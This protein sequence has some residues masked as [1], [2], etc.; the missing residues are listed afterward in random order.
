M[1]PPWLFTCTG[2]VI[3]SPC[4]VEETNSHELQTRNTES[5]PRIGENSNKLH[6]SFRSPYPL[7]CSNQTFPFV[8]IILSDQSISKSNRINQNLIPAIVY[9]LFPFLP[10][11]IFPFP[12]FFFLVRRFVRRYY[13]IHS[14]TSG[15]AIPFHLYFRLQFIPIPSSPLSVPPLLPP[16]SLSRTWIEPPSYLTR[17]ILFSR[18]SSKATN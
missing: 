4:I 15:Q 13:P 16:L 11:N 12:F 1:F 14:P 2:I 18:R 5:C 7:L 8:A 10:S 9:F 3:D 6:H 17:I